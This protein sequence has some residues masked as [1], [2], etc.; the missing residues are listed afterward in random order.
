[1]KRLKNNKIYG[2]LSLR[3]YIVTRVQE[4]GVKGD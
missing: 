1:M 3:Y 4:N 2:Y